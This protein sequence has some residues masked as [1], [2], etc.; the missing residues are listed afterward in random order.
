MLSGPTNTPVGAASAANAAGPGLAID[1]M[2]A[3]SVLPGGDHSSDCS[4]ER[5]A[6]R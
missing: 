6:V 5:T 4:S 2:L 3:A 1:A